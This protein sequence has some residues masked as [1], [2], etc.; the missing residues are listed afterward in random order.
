MKKLDISICMPSYNGMPYIQDT[1]SCLLAQSFKDFEL[2]VC[3]DLSTDNT[4]EIVNSFEDSRIRLLENEANVGYGKNVDR[5]LRFANNEIIVL[6]GQDDIVCNG[7][8]QQI[9]DIFLKYPKVGVLTRAYYWF[10]GD[11]HTPVRDKS[12][13]DPQGHVILSL[14]KAEPKQVFRAF[15]SMDQLSGLA[16][17]REWIEDPVQEH[18]FT[19][20]VYPMAAIWKNH[21]LM[22]LNDYTIA[23]RIESSQARY[24][25]SIYNPSPVWTWV[26]LFNSVYPEPEFESIRRLCI[27]NYV[28]KNYL[29]LVQIRNYGRFSWLLREIGM[30]LRYRPLNFF[31]LPFWFFSM[32][33]IALPSSVLIKLADWYKKRVLSSLIG[34]IKFSY[35]FLTEK[36]S[37]A[38]SGSR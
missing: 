18:V 35:T 17:R 9:H 13:V 37:K 30:L 32:G 6:M 10:H 19:A 24:V 14:R 22:C 1:V 2:I 20:H 21:D 25:S 34:K 3:D 33:C 15:S 36:S 8:L 16:M 27:R 28:A 29:G 23:V 38:N 11:I 7:M 31:S 4:C 5:C 12:P 26:Q